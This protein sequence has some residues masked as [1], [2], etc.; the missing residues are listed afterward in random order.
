VFTGL[1][2]EIGT[3]RSVRR[4]GDYQHMDFDARVVVR[5]ARPGDSINV[6]GVCQ[7][8]TRCG[9][10]SFSV[11]TLAETLKKTTLGEMRPGRR[12]NLE[13]SLTP[14]A[15]LGGHLVQGHVDAT[16][17]VLLV[18]REG[19]NAYLTIDLPEELEMYVVRE[20]SIAINGVSL[21]IAALRGTRVTVNLIPVTWSATAL[22]DLRVHDRANVE[23]DIIGRYVAKMLGKASG[24]ESPRAGLSAEQ[25]E[26]WGY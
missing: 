14:D 19:A 18:S 4:S 15:R 12:V 22:S 13:R 11:D 9:A 26:A 25:L 23:V 1:V 8:V 16:A 20:G 5:D 17:R 21:T 10:D 7:T 2:E 3:V 24:G 6:D